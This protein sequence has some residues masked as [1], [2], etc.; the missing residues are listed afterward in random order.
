MIACAC[1]FVST[2]ASDSPGARSV[3]APFPASW[4]DSLMNCIVHM[5]DPEGSMRCSGVN[6]GHSDEQ[7]WPGTPR[8][9]PRCTRLEGRCGMGCFGRSNSLCAGIAGELFAFGMP[10]AFYSSLCILRLIA[11]A[12]FELCTSTGVQRP[13]PSARSCPAAARQQSRTSQAPSRPIPLTF[14][15]T[16]TVRSNQG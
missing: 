16:R 14:T 8:E 5:H 6:G 10:F 12:F 3:R 15:L 7:V 9:S 11:I 2:S 1:R 13:G 4:A